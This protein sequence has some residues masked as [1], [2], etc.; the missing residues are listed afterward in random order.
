MLPAFKVGI[1]SPNNAG[2]DGAGTSSGGVT[3]ALG[4]AGATVLTDPQDIADALSQIPDSA[5]AQ[6]AADKK[7]IEEENEL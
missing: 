2:I 3:S 4:V 1:N 6:V 5:A 7:K